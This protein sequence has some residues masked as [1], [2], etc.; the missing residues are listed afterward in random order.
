MLPP[1]GPTAAQ[2]EPILRRAYGYWN[3]SGLPTILSARRTGFLIKPMY[4]GRSDPIG[5]RAGPSVIARVI[6]GEIIQ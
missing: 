6:F 2:R 4:D 3:R 1:F 5:A